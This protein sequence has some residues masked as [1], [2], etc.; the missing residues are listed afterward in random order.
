MLLVGEE[1]LQLILNLRMNESAGLSTLAKEL[2]RL[3]NRLYCELCGSWFYW[4]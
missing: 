1:D 3:G 2:Q 4:S